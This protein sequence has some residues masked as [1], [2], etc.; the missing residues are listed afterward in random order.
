MNTTPDAVWQTYGGRLRHLVESRVRHPQDADDLL[1]DLF[2]KIQSGLGGVENPDRLEAWV[3]QV[4]RRAIID[5]Y[6]R[7][8]SEPRTQAEMIDP[9]EPLP[10]PDVA[11]EIASWLRPLMQ[12]LPARDREALELTDLQGLGQREVADRLGLSFTGAKSRI[13]RARS[14]LKEVLLECCDI[15]LDRRG[16]TL[17]YAPRRASCSCESCR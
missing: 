17:E 8:S 12:Q 16:N 9:A 13:Q 3:F 1:Q 14:R 4:T 2:S 7:R 11:A 10:E 15:A 5:Y 6:R